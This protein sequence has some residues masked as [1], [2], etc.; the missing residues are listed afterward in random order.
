MRPRKLTEQRFTLPLDNLKVPVRLITETRQGPRATLG[1]KALIVRVPPL[2]DPTLRDRMLNEMLDWARGVYADR[3][4]AFDHFRAA[5]PANRYRFTVRDKEHEIRVEEHQL[6]SHRIRPGTGENELI[7]TVNPTDGRVADGRL[8]PKLLAKHFGRVHLPRVRERVLA[9]NDAHFGQTVNA[10]KLSDTYSRWGSCS[11]KGNINLAT[12][13]VL[14][15]DAVLDAVIIHE[16]AHLIEANHSPAFWAQVERALPNYRE[17][18]A[19]LREH[20]DGLVF[21]P[22]PVVEPD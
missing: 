4:A 22:T 18:D 16:L 1:R 10:V 9:L 7:V 15:P 12:R 17:Y 11:S 3:P 13:L 6:R 8:L 2:A 21:R 20:G 19:W 14:A 5:P